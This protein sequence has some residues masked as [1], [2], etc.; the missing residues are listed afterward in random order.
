MYALGEGAKQSEWDTSELARAA[1]ERDRNKAV[2]VALLLAEKARI[3]AEDKAHEHENLWKEERRENR[4]TGKSLGSCEEPR[5]DPAPPA[6]AGDL[7]RGDS[8][9]GVRAP[10]VAGR[11]G[12]L[13]HWRFVGMYDGAHSAGRIHGEPIFGA[14][15]EYA[16]APERADTASPYTLDDVLD[17][18]GE[19]AFEWGKCRRDLN[20]AIDLVEAAEAAYERGKR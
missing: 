19:N 14:T 8:G 4:R 5:P 11:P 2:G 13:L 10:G 15:A 18:H 1:H 16:L 9:A 12:V 3:A 20:A 7:A 6:G 17:V